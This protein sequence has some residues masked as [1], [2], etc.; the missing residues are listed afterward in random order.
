MLTPIKNGYIYEQ[1]YGG[2]TPMLYQL[3][4]GAL[5]DGTVGFTYNVFTSSPYAQGFQP[6]T[7]R[8]IATSLTDTGYAA[9][10][11]VTLSR[12][13][14]RNPVLAPVG[15]QLL[16]LGEGG[17]S[18][19]TSTYQILGV[20]NGTVTEVSAAMTIFGADFSTEYTYD[21]APT[22]FLPGTTMAFVHRDADQAPSP[23][24]Y[25]SPTASIDLVNAA[26]NTPAHAPIVTGLTGWLDLRGVVPVDDSTAFSAAGPLNMNGDSPGGGDTLRMYRLGLGDPIVTSDLSIPVMEYTRIY[27]GVTGSYPV[28]TF[29]R[30]DSATTATRYGISY[31]DD[32]GFSATQLPLEQID[33]NATPPDGDGTAMLTD[34]HPATYI[35]VGDQLFVVRWVITPTHSGTPYLRITQYDGSSGA[36]VDDVW[37]GAATPGVASPAA[38]QI[39]SQNTSY[40]AA[41][42]DASL[43]QLAVGTTEL[44]F[45]TAS[46]FQFAMALRLATFQIVSYPISQQLR[47]TG[48]AFI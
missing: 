8:A 11:P 45:Q 10:S 5:G 22:A 31:D 26:S 16:F 4:A 7:T 23:D 40:P 9:G 3:V 39:T 29:A 15:K 2:N 14:I 46:P 48:S 35:P 21:A 20:A 34:L 30:G 43:N 13:R 37:T 38:V 41:F 25:L 6:W 24:S 47:S 33:I 18:D 17:P 28:E 1:A 19:S 44:R 12:R 36:I 27:A 42:Y 32:S